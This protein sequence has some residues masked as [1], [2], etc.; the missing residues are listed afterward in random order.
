MG[1]W[2]L[3][4]S[5]L[6]GPALV[7]C[8]VALARSPRRGIALIGACV[9]VAALPPVLVAL[10]YDPSPTAHEPWPRGMFAAAAAMVGVVLADL[11][12][13]AG[14]ALVTF[15]APATRTEH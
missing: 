10:L 11:T 14:F 1:L 12:A 3:L 15:T 9:A 8:L 2:I 6:S 13:F 7:L 4:I 5:F